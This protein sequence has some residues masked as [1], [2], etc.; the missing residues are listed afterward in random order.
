MRLPDH[1]LT[2][3]DYPQLASRG[4]IAFRR[5]PTMSRQ[6]LNRALRRQEKILKA[7]GFRAN[8][9]TAPCNRETRCDK[10]NNCIITG[11]TDGKTY[12]PFYHWC[13]MMGQPVCPDGWCP[14]GR[15]GWGPVVQV[16][17]GQMTSLPGSSAE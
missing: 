4:F 10:C 9:A 8:G 16:L 1:T 5:R 11:L 2:P 12:K 6:K 13:Q 14:Q 15:C 7:F 3:A 17:R